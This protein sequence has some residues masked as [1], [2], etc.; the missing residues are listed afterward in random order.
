MMTW[1]EFAAARPDLAGAGERLIQQFGVGL[2]FLATVR[3]DGGPR[4]HPVCPVIGEG[5]LYLF[6]VA[7]SPKRAD[8][9]RDG[10]YALH[11]YPVPQTDESFYCTG[12]AQLV[13]DPQIRAAALAA[14]K[15]HVQD[16]EV[17]FELA[18]DSALHTTWTGWGTPAMRPHHERWR[19]PQ[20][21]AD[22]S[23]PT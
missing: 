1:G 20:L 13:T 12:R 15:H 7:T 8:L 11:S 3:K 9:V 21:V 23:A 5:R 18:V 2:G 19:A 14:A 6:V 17:L 4:V 22:V 10:R 16:D